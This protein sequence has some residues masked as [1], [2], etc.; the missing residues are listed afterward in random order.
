[1]NDY[2]VAALLIDIFCIVL[3]LLYVYGNVGINFT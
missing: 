1:M 3:S 2:K